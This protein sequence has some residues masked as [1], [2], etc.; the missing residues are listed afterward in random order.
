MLPQGQK[1]LLTICLEELVSASF[2]NCAKHVSKKVHFIQVLKYLVF[3]HPREIK[4]ILAKFM[5]IRIGKMIFQLGWIN[6][7]FSFYLLAEPIKFDIKGEAAILM[8]AQSGVVLFEHEAHI[9]HYPASTTKV[10]TALYALKQHGEA[11]DISIE[12]EQESVVAIT[13]KAKSKSNFTLPAYWLEPDGMHI[14][15]KK[16]EIF[17][18]RDLLKGMLIPSGNDA[19]NVIA[20]A[21]GPTIPTF[22]EGLNAYLKE[23]GCQQ[24]NF[25]NPHGLHDPKH[26]TTAY[27]LALI[28]REALKYAVFCEIVSQTRFMRPKTNKQSAMT[29]LQTNRLMRPGKFHYSKAIGVKT[30][31]HVKAKKTLIAA[32]QADGRTLIAV[33]LGY[34]D[35]NAIY[36]DAIKLFEFAFNQPK[37]QRVFFKAGPQTFSL[38]LPQTSCTLQTYLNEPLTLDYYPAEDPQVK[39]FLY[40]KSLQL[41]ILKDQLVGDLHLVSAEGVV[42]KQVP[43]WAA[44]DV[45]VS[46]LYRWLA[47]LPSLLWLLILG[48]GLVLFYIS[49]R[50]LG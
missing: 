28:T 27:D 9:P 11:L 33:L 22:M 38:D 29:L 49:F 30:G 15:I 32:A 42:L 4:K 26:Q 1:A 20:Q 6:V 10:A 13:Q 3:M 17:T 25:C 44:K 46:W 24:T 5:Q 21:L 31:Y 34:Q 18:L 36:E 8:N 37:V 19:A 45:K 7:L 39:C 2:V 23:I 48:G 16:G 43:L 41:P 50:T 47:T 14:G 40:W 12:A 35:R